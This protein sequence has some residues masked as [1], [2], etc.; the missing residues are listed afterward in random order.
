MVAAMSRLIRRWWAGGI[1]LFKV[2]GDAPIVMNC[3][4]VEY[5]QV[6]PANCGCSMPLLPR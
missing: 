3:W 2:G 1:S 4:G 6:N 5:E